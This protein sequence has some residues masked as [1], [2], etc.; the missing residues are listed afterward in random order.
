MDIKK[1]IKEHGWTLERLASEM[2]NKRE[3][4]KGMSQSSL[5]QLLNGST[6]LDRLQEIARIIGV[7]L[8]ELVKDENQ[9]NGY[10]EVGGELKKVTS[11][12]ELE[13][14]LSEIKGER[15]PILHKN[16]RGKEYFEKKAEE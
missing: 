2:T 13:R 10:I 15:P 4:K 11:V 14:V 5:S 9:I 8:S 12:E 3:N 7:S 1:V 6:P 16:I